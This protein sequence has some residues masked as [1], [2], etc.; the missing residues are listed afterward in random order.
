[1][2]FS[3]QMSMCTGVFVVW[4]CA[5][6]KYIINDSVSI[7]LQ[8]PFVFWMAWGW[9]YQSHFPPPSEVSTA[10][11]NFFLLFFFLLHLIRTGFLQ[12]L[13]TFQQSPQRPTY[14][15]KWPA[16]GQESP[17]AATSPV[18]GNKQQEGKRRMSG[19]EGGVERKEGGDIQNTTMTRRGLELAYSFCLCAHTHI[20]A[21]T[22]SVGERFRGG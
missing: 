10:N 16:G 22:L 3:L 19:E 5:E 15:P 18:T 2:Y 6:Q 12:D 20:Q 4:Y 17:G 9:N 14:L 21:H 7:Q 11:N 1:M 13:A 8:A